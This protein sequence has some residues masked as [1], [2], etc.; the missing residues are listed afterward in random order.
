MVEARRENAAEPK[1]EVLSNVAVKPERKTG[2][3]CAG[4]VLPQRDH[5]NDGSYFQHPVKNV[6]AQDVPGAGAK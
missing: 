3:L 2:E 5:V 1:N 6:V 4:G